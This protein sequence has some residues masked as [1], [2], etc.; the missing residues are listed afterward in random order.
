MTLLYRV[1]FNKY[2]VLLLILFAGFA[3]RYQYIDKSNFNFVSGG[4]QIIYLHIADGMSRDHEFR[5]EPGLRSFMPPMHPWILT[6]L[7]Y[8]FGQDLKVFYLFYFLLSS[9]T[10]LLLFFIAKTL[11]NEFT[12]IAAAL[13]FLCYEDIIYWTTTM[14]TETPFLFF[15]VF[16]LLCLFLYSKRNNI[17]FLAAGAVFFTASF[18]SRSTVLLLLPF[19]PVHIYLNSALGSKKRLFHA[20]LFILIVGALMAPWTIRNY[21]IHKTIVLG[22]TNGGMNFYQGNNPEATGGMMWPSTFRQENY[23]QRPELTETGQDAYYYTEGKKWIRSNPGKFLRLE[24]KKLQALLYPAI[25]PE[26]YPGKVSED[27]PAFLINWHDLVKLGILGFIL[28]FR[29]FKEW[30][31]LYSAAFVTIFSAMV[32]YGAQ[33]YRFMLDISMIIF[34]AYFICQT[35]EYL[36]L[37]LLKKE[38]NLSN[39]RLYDPTL[40]A[41]GAAILFL[42]LVAAAVLFTGA[43]RLMFLHG[44]DSTAGVTFD[45]R[46]LKHGPAKFENDSLYMCWPSFVD[47][48]LD[49]PAGEYRLS[50]TAYGSPDKTQY[51]KMVFLLN[52]QNISETAVNDRKV[53]YS[54]DFRH[55]GNIAD[56]YIWNNGPPGTSAHLFNI[57]IKRLRINP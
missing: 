17:L 52:K 15:Y 41:I 8:L 48:K 3:I 38:I 57:N 43:K 24:L 37:K 40:K 23:W 30:I 46:A 50:F 7:S 4:D 56:I 5:M 27:R 54:V 9:L 21:G 18:Y 53:T 16:L 19:I 29:R 1:L 32:Y 36:S 39:F 14:Y 47:K 51:P 31:I 33:R 28:G 6:G 20:G 26:S 35:V 55:G 42:A 22:S 11:V 49:L 13:I 34:A 10:A 2:T 25:T 12:G 44:L 45:A